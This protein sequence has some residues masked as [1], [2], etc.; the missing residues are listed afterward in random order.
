M[1]GSYNL[2][3]ELCFSAENQEI[4]SDSEERSAFQEKLHM[5]EIDNTF[6]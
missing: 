3:L 2:L 4:H 1:H 5:S 6:L